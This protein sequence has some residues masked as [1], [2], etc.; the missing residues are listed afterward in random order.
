MPDFEEHQGDSV[1]HTIGTFRRHF[2]V[3]TLVSLLRQEYLNAA[4]DYCS[5]NI[6]SFTDG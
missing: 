4:I 6:V 3:A 5:R 1:T 2:G